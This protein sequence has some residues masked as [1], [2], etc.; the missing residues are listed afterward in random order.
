MLDNATANA[1]LDRISAT[2][3]NRV[4]IEALR[5]LQ[6]CHILSVP[7]ENLGYHL[8]E[9]IHMDERVVNKIVHKRRGGG[10][11]ELNPAFYFLLRSLGFNTEMKQGKV[12]I[13]GKLGPPLCHL[14]LA[15]KFEAD[16]W[17][18][19]V[20][21]GRNSRY[22]LLLESANP[23]ADPHGE[24]R[25]RKAEDGGTDVLMND[26]PQYRIY[27]GPCDLADFAPTLW[28][29]RT[30]PDSPFLQNLFCSL[31]SNN[32][33]V[34]LQ[35]DTLTVIDGNDRRTECLTDAPALL[36]AYDKWF[37]VKLDKLPVKA[38]PQGQRKSARIS[39]D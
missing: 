39:F 32:G 33:R 11:Y 3:P 24:Y 2:R 35:E 26:K 4:D 21:F 30:S 19:D 22:P 6:E 37:G 38:T 14:A 9:E 5:R 17:L 15:V 27:D 29:Y 13:K 20:G 34:T 10:C 18:V 25:L 16:S 28:W 12:W 23:Q 8:N 36:E 31:P 1:Y 7:F